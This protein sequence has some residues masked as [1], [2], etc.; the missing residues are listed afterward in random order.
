MQNCSLLS[1]PI[2]KYV[3]RKSHRLAIVRVD[4]ARVGRATHVARLYSFTNRRDI[5]NL[6][7]D[8]HSTRLKFV[9]QTAIAVTGTVA[10]LSGAAPS[11]AA[12]AYASA[13]KSLDKGRLFL[14]YPS[15][16]RQLLSALVY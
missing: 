2:K 15:I 7:N 12:G 4:I 13:L 16:K 11:F 8:S 5:M 10:L 1:E 9:Q 6:R 14:K 3:T